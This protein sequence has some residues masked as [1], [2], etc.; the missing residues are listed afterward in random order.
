MERSTYYKIAV[1]AGTLALS[2]GAF[3]WKVRNKIIERD[4]GKCRLCGSTEHLEA[5]H[6]SHDKKNPRYNEESN[7]MTLDTNCHLRDHIN[8]H[9]RNGLTKK[10]NEWAIERLKERATIVYQSEEVE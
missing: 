5:A 9:G 10:Q 2:T 6:I 8:R 1:V 7:G 3:S 4:G